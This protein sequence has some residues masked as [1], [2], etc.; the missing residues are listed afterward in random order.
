MS[1]KN[2]LKVLVQRASPLRYLEKA[3]KALFSVPKNR[4][5]SRHY[6][7]H[8]GFF[9][10]SWQ[11]FPNADLMSPF[12]WGSSWLFYQ[13][14]SHCLP[15]MTTTTL[16]TICEYPEWRKFFFFFE[17]TNSQDRQQ[18]QPYFR[19]LSRQQSV[20]LAAPKINSIRF[21]TWTAVGRCARNAHAII[22]GKIVRQ[23]S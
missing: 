11:S 19:H 6:S 3:S 22:C 10:K 13:F 15:C 9:K 12:W 16:E 17:N 14:G 2:M 8:F 18:Q 1:L 5:W 7:D 20:W 21:F 23:L 4:V